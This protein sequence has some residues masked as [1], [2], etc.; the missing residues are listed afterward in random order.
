MDFYAYKISFVS[1]VADVNYSSFVLLVE[2][3]LADDVG[4]I[5]MDLYLVSKSVKCKVSSC[6]ELHLDAEQV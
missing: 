4:N 3:K 5:E 1:S 6:A 2:S